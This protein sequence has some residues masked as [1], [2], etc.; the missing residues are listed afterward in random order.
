MSWQ[1]VQGLWVFYC[2]SVAVVIYHERERELF[3]GTHFSN[4]YEAYEVKNKREKLRCLLL[5]REKKIIILYLCY[6]CEAIFL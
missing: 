3:I 6:D 2:L 4:L 5:R 1:D